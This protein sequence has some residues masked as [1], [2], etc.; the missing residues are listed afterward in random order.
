MQNWLHFTNMAILISFDWRKIIPRRER[1]KPSQFIKRR[2]NWRKN[3]FFFIYKID[4]KVCPFLGWW[5][6]LSAT[7]FMACFADFY[8]DLTVKHILEHIVELS[9]QLT[10]C[11]HWKLTPTQPYSTAFENCW[12]ANLTC[13]QQ[14][15]P[16]RFTLWIAV[17][18][19]LQSQNYKILISFSLSLAFL[20]LLFSFILEIKTWMLKSLFNEIKV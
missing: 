5:W 19:Q 12:W 4:I 17:H 7:R 1:K 13:S 14:L 2:W 20:R 9:T 6:L 15:W 8:D 10:M 16:L 18:G 3:F 11:K